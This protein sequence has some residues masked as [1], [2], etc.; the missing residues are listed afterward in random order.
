MMSYNLGV[1]F[2]F[3]S[4]KLKII[5]FLLTHFFG[6]ALPGRLIYDFASIYLTQTKG[7][8]I[9]HGCFGYL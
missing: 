6:L 4:T 1:V 9:L 8:F 3:M 5:S 2:L 7:C